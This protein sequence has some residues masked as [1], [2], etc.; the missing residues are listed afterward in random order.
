[1]VK[2]FKKF[3]KNEIPKDKLK[4][5]FGGKHSCQWGDGRGGSMSCNGGK[6]HLMQ[7]DTRD[8]L[9][10]TSTDTAGL[11]RERGTSS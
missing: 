1:M 8:C 4:F 7:S 3:S 5:I 10:C 9:Y 2:S 11:C 6:C